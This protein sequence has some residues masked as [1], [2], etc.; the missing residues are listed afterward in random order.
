MMRIHISDT[1]ILPGSGSGSASAACA[2]PPR[3]PSGDNLSAGPKCGRGFTPRRVGAS[4]R[5]GSQISSPSLSALALLSALTF[6]LAL[7]G[8]APTPPSPPPA[9]AA[10]AWDWSAFPT[11]DRLL[12]A[13]QSAHVGP[14][15]TATL[16]APASGTLRLTEKLD[17]DQPLAA[18]AVWARIEP[19]DTELET[20]AVH[21]LETEIARR[22]QQYL[23]LE[24]PALLAQLDRELRAAEELAAAAAFAEREPGLFSGERPALDPLLRPSLSSAQAAQAV[25]TLRER[26][27]RLTASGATAEPPELQALRAELER[28][29]SARDFRARQLRLTAP[30]AGR[31][32]LAER[33]DG[34]TVVAGETLALIADPTALRI[35]VP[36]VS[37]LLLAVPAESLEVELT[38]PAGGLVRARFSTRSFDS[39]GEPMLWFEAPAEPATVETLG[40]AGVQLPARIFTRLAAPALIVPKL[41]LAAHDTA[42]R[43]AAGWREAVPQLFPAARFVAEGR[44]TVAVQPPPAAR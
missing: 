17:P 22:R 10:P 41:A 24:R 4:P 3:S 32:A 16:R 18:G 7:T 23:D 6:T 19:E 30:F 44:T 35:G 40:A 38:L 15:R 21:R 1:R 43:L 42:D 11:A 5:I 14:A 31:L 27:E 37:P 8:C 20:E 28:R 13:H 12:L 9:A 25:T 33:R 26:R 2:A 34:R 36:P 29:A 39:S